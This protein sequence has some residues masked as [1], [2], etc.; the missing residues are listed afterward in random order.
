ME[1]LQD[2]THVEV[3]S[4]Q[5][6]FG[7][8]KWLYERNKDKC[9]D[10]NISFVKFADSNCGQEN[11]CHHFVQLKICFYVSSVEDV[12]LFCLF[13]LFTTADSS[14]TEGVKISHIH[15]KRL[16]ID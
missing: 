15:H 14:H 3:R 11:E 5:R 10:A 16:K 4:E 6:Y 1:I 13:Y 7:F 8:A 2:V 12:R 9:Y